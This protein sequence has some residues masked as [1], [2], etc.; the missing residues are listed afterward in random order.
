MSKVFFDVGLS[1]D[2]FMAGENRGPKN[3]LGDNGP[4]IHQWMF[5]QKAF[6]KHLGQ[7]G[8]NEEGPD[9]ALFEKTFAR[10]GAYIM[11]KRMFEEGE[12]NWPEDLY[13]AP[14]YVVTH[15]KRQPWVQKGS[16]TFYFVNDR[17]ESA[18]KMA[19]ANAKGKD[20]RI[21]GGVNIIQQYRKA[22]EPQP[23]SFL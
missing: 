22:D 17:I 15:E 8:G 7:E 21:Q 10:A 13:K 3:P 14:V 18:L 5:Q 4:T 12:V 6:W 19:K 9:N 1:L 23:K 11:G 16:T 2:G 20:I